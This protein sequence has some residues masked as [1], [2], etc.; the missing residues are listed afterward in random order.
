MRFGN[1]LCPGS[2]AKKS[3]KLKFKT[4][5]NSKPAVKNPYDLI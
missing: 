2:L 1:F 4:T 5:Q 3:A